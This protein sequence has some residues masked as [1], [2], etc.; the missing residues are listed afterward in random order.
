MT[1][2]IIEQAM[3]AINREMRVTHE[4]HTL[5]ALGKAYKDLSQVLRQSMGLEEAPKHGV[6]APKLSLPS[7]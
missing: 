7:K 4:Y 3:A 2:L 5:V 6:I 1:E